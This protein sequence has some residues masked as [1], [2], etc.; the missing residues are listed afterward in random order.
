VSRLS[1]RARRRLVTAGIVA[2]VAAVAMV[3]SASLLGYSN[4][5]MDEHFIVPI[6]LGFL[7][8]DLNPHWF[9]YHPLPMYLLGAIYY[10]MYL[11]ARLFGLVASRPEFVALLFS[12]DAVFYIP[13]KLLGSFA[14]TG[15][16][17]VLGL[18]AWRRTGSR[19]AAAL[20]F[21]A[22]LLTADGIVTGYNVRNDSF[23]FLFAALTVYF[24][25]F[26][27][28]GPAGA[29]LAVV[30]CAAAFASKIPAVVLAPVLFAQLAWDAW[31]GQ[32]RWR[33]VGY[34]AVLFPVAAFL[35]NPFAVL[36]FPHYL[37]TLQWVSARVAGGLEKV[38]VQSYSGTAERVH[39]LARTMLRECGVVAVAGSVLYAAHTAVR[40]RAMLFPPLFALAYATAFV[41]SSQVN[42]WW[43][44]PVY[45]MLL[46]FPVLL[47]A[48]VAAM[49][50][51]AALAVRPGARDGAA[52][53]RRVRG[54]LLALL[55]A[56]YLGTLAPNLPRAAAAVLPAP[57]DT[58][59]TAARWIRENLPA[60]AEV[61]L[62]GG[63]PHYW[64][65]VFSPDAPT[66]LIVS[67]YSYPFVW[68]NRVLMAGFRRY[69]LDA[70][71]NEKPFRVW[72][73]TRNEGAGYDTRRLHLPAGA[74]VV[75][76]EANYARYYRPEVAR[77]HPDLARN[78]QAF[79]ALI[80]G[81]E[82]V[83]T[84]TGAGPTIEIYRMREGLNGGAG[85]PRP[86]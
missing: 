49:P 29:L 86:Q 59:V 28:K 6:A 57:E 62:E 68:Q 53:V 79:F 42:A 18:A 2:A 74:Y 37:P 51:V 40:D 36:D 72:P 55:A 32:L 77:D 44:R 84:F 81:Q 4:W 27:R 50:R 5:I 19:A 73:M 52:A 9:G 66:T 23:V 35:F 54:I 22:P 10:V 43:L 65:R 70:L 8:G 64:P 20:A 47:V 7:G 76:S 30:C 33:H 14:F 3:R 46:L 71:K 58:R 45:P 31:H 25:C 48:A 16:A 21:A 34:C 39:N 78:A 80:R 24:A 56:G 83:R 17:A 63:L 75:L 61:I 85:T 60:G 12:H 67:Q 69:Y 26:A 11:G 13:A 82:P 1:D 41:T 38:G 15:G